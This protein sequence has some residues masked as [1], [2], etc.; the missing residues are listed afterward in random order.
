[1]R[2]SYATCDFG[3]LRIVLTPARSQRGSQSYG[4]KNLLHSV[5]G[6]DLYEAGTGGH[7]MY[8][9]FQVP[10]RGARDDQRHIERAEIGEVVER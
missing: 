3:V 8:R 4:G 2:T 5:I 7:E 6:N 10:A 9:Q 1:V